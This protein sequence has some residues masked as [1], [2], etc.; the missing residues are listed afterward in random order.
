MMIPKLLSVNVFFGFVDVLIRPFPKKY[1]SMTGWGKGH[2]LF[3]TTTD[4]QI[5]ASHCLK[6]H[7][8]CSALL[9]STVLEDDVEPPFMAAIAC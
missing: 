9:T 4:L 6:G 2:M 7:F 3:P 8:G 1:S 5:S